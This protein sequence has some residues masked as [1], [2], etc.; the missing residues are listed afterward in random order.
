MSHQNTHTW[1]IMPGLS[2]MRFFVWALNISDSL[3]ILTTLVVRQGGPLMLG[4]GYIRTAFSLE[5]LEILSLSEGKNVE[6]WS[7]VH[8]TRC[9]S[10]SLGKM[11]FWAGIQWFSHL[12][13]VIMFVM[14]VDCHNFFFFQKSTSIDGQ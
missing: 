3:Y 1:K 13:I 8:S 9:L 7:W 10:S 11:C 14:V 2:Y 6:F 12:I 4:E 5:S